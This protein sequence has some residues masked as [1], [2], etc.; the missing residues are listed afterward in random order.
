MKYG[1]RAKRAKYEKILYFAFYLLP[2][3]IILRA[4]V[5]TKTVCVRNR[6]DE[7]KKKKINIK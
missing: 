4:I 5:T 6:I 2:N 7:E 1:M 3:D